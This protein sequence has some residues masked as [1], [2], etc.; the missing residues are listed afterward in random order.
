M[1]A[2]MSLAVSVTVQLFGPA[3]VTGPMGVQFEDHPP[4]LPVP[5]GAVKITV[6]PAG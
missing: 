6:A 1:A 3:S 4:N 5:A 2:T